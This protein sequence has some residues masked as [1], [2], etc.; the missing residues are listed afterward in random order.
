MANKEFSA[1]IKKWYV[2]AYPTD[3]LGPELVGNFAG[4]LETM[5]KGGDIY[6]YMGVGDSL[7]RERLFTRLSEML[8][9]DYD[10]IYE[11]WLNQSVSPE[12]RAKAEE[13][14]ITLA[15][16]AETPSLYKVLGQPC[17][18]GAPMAG[19]RWNIV[20][21]STKRRQHDKTGKSIQG[22]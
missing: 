19:T 6:D 11:L 7:V 2:K 9:I 8:G 22:L 20:W 10:H 1:S 5:A 4:A 15:T 16:E 13:N 14:G 18:P 3:D 21:A 12:L 17:S